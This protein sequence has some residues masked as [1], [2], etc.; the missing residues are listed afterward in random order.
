VDRRRIVRPNAD[1]STITTVIDLENAPAYQTV[2]D[3][4]TITPPARKPQ[5]AVTGRRYGGAR[6]VGE[7]HDDN[8]L[9]GWTTLVGGATADA[10]LDNMSALLEQLEQVQP[11][12]YIEWRPDGATNSVYYEVREPAT[13]KPSYRWVQ[14]AGVRSL[15]CDVQVLVAPLA[16]EAPYVEEFT[17]AELP[18]VFALAAAVRGDAPALGD[19][20]IKRSSGVLPAGWGMIAWS[21]RPSAGSDPAPWGILTDDSLIGT[22]D[23]VHGCWRDTTTAG[24]S[25]HFHDFTVDTT[26]I[27]A[28]PFSDEITVE[29]WGR[30]ETGASYSE[31]SAIASY[32]SVAGADEIYT[33]EFASSGRSLLTGY[34]G[35]AFHRLGTLTIPA[36]VKGDTAGRLRVMTTWDG[37]ASE[38]GLDY[39][40]VVPVG[41][42]A[43]NMTAK[44][45][46]YLFPGIGTP[47]TAYTKAILADLSGR[48]AASALSGTSFPNGTSPGMGGAPIELPPGDVDV[49][50]KLSDMN[51][52]AL[53]GA[54]G[55][56]DQDDDMESTVSVRVTPRWLL[57]R[58]A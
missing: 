39:V 7:T 16:V 3:T 18:A 29:V 19:V 51:P 58:G 23:Y 54:G 27:P 2:A 17:V 57:A 48:I 47:V 35:L 45:G 10:T 41:Q 22:G 25:S 24:P 33:A 42:R 21:Q 44:P 46:R 53:A 15:S 55:G 31:A 11:G 14:F 56:G 6:T 26:R 4:W 49:L 8:G 40:I 9:I 36:G 28:D 1:W 37:A 52:D 50:I 32:R 30:F 20:R 38:I 5:L 43:A 12:L 13:W 34:A